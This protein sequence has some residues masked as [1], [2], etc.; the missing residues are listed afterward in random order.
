[1]GKTEKDRVTGGD[2]KKKHDS[3]RSRRNKGCKVMRR[4]MRAVQKE[5]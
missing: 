1:M 4:N 3:K 5:V 2:T